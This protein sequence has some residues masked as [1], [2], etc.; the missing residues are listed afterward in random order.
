MRMPAPATELPGNMALGA[1]RKPRFARRA[2]A[3]TAEE[4]RAVGINQN[5]APVADVLVNPRNS[6]IGVRSFSSD[7]GLAARLTASWVRG[8]RSQDVAATAKHFPGHGDAIQDSPTGFPVLD[9][10]RAQVESIDLPPF[11]AAID[12][13]V[14]AILTAHIVAPALDPSGRPTTFSRP[15]LTGLLRDRLGFDGVIVADA[16][17]LENVQRRFGDARA[18][19]EAIKAGADV[20]L[21]PQRIGIAYDAVLNAVRSGEISERRIDESVERILHL[22]RRAGVLDDPPV[23]EGKVAST[24]GAPEHVADAEAITE[25]TTTLVANDAGT[26]PLKAGTGARLLVTGATAT[27]TLAA[28]IS[29]R[30]V[31]AQAFETGATPTDAQIDEAAGRAAAG[32]AVVVLTSNA[33]ASP[34]QQKLVEALAD[35]GKPVI[36]VAVDAPD[37][38]AFLPDVRTYLATYGFRAVSLRALTR[39]LFGEVKPRGRL[40]VDITAPG[41]PGTILYPFGHGL[42]FG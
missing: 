38:I 29:E 9:H 4:L 1:A 28:E 12:A 19:I 10:T 3:I 32:D 6:V 5:I 8:T 23:D 11:Q 21:I 7:P 35:A 17:L 16:L 22:K 33:S 18:A 41:E 20:L 30:G 40:P 24:V 2:G 27:A 26:V 39:V 14:P 13:G 25:R 36:A 31:N 34:Q 15:I 37:D 42:S